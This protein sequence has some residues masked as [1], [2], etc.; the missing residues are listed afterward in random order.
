MA[1]QDK[2]REEPFFFIGMV[3][4]ITKCHPHTLR[5]YEQMGF[6]KPLRKG[7][8]RVYSLRDIARI[9]VIRTLTQDFGVN[10]AGVEIILNLMDKIRELESKLQEKPTI[11]LE[12][13]GDEK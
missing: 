4:K 11:I 1:R 8:K 5:L 13:E 6:V 12:Q 10:L 9:K 2:D 7:G 3:A